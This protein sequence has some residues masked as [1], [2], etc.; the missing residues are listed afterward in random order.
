MQVRYQA[1]PR[2]DTETQCYVAHGVATTCD[3]KSLSPEALF[4][5]RVATMRMR[6]V[7]A[8]PR[9]RA[10]V[11]GYRRVVAERRK[12]SDEAAALPASPFL[13]DRGVNSSR[14]TQLTP[15]WD[16]I[17][18][19]V[20]NNR[21]CFCFLTVGATYSMNHKSTLSQHDFNRLRLVIAHD[22]QRQPITRAIG[23]NNALQMIDAT[24][25]TAVHR[26]NDV[27]FK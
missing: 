12:P 15:N 9:R 7:A 10:M 14:R 13:A 21:L 8:S 27:T 6:P 4:V 26:E 3:V 5:P 18:N 23:R 24:R 20:Y 11:H 1:A 16:R 17:A 2:P 22:L 25:L 19:S